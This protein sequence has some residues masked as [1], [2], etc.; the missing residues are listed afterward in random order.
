MSASVQDD[1]LA[2]PMP[3]AEVVAV[4]DEE[5]EVEGDIELDLEDRK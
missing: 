2:G 4:V 3:E 1:A 5:D